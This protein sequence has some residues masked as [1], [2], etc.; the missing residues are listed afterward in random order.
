MPRSAFRP[1]ELVLLARWAEGLR[2]RAASPQPSLV[3]GQPPRLGASGHSHPPAAWQPLRRMADGMQ[4]RAVPG[5][6]QQWAA[7]S[8]AAGQSG[9]ARGRSEV[10]GVGWPQCRPWAAR[11][12]PLE[13]ACAP[14]HAGAAL[15]ALPFACWRESLSARRRAW[16]HATDRSWAGFLVPHA[17]LQSCSGRCRLLGAQTAHGPCPPR[18]PPVNWSASCRP[19]GRAPPIRQESDGS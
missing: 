8:A 1:A 2:Q 14:A 19:K 3:E 6:P 16:R 10:R 9:A 18:S 11:A 12:L 4:S 15:P 13:V 7:R 17:T 5:E